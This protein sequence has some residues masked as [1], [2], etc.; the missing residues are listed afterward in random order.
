MNLIGIINFDFSNCS[1]IFPLRSANLKFSI[2]N[3][4]SCLVNWETNGMHALIRGS[5]LH[6]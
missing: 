1:E 4:Y 3:V 6:Q 5:T 2:L